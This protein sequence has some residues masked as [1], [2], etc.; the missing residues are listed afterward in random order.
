MNLKRAIRLL[1]TSPLLQ[2]VL[3]AID[4][5]LWLVDTG[6]MWSVRPSKPEKP[7]VLLLKL[8]S[9]G[10]YLLVRNYV[11]LLKSHPDYQPYSFCLAGNVAFRQMAEFADADL[12]DSFIWIDI[13][14]VSTRPLYR[15]AVARQLHKRGFIVSI[16]PTYSRVLVLD[17]FLTRVAGATVRIGCTTDLANCSRLEAN[18]G[19]HYFSRLVPS[20]T[21]VVF[22]A[23]RNRQLFSQLLGE[24][25]PL[26]VL[27]LPPAPKPALTLPDSFVIVSP[28]AGAPDKIWPMDRFADS[29]V[30]L[31]SLRPDWYIVVTGT[32]AE[33]P[34]YTQLRQYLPAPIHLESLMGKLS[35][36]ELVWVVD[37]AALV[38]A[39]DSGIVHIAAAVGTP[40]LSLSAGKAIVRWHP[41]PAEI[42]PQVRHV[43]PAFFDEW[44]GRLDELAPQVV[45][46]AP[47]PIEQLTVDRVKEAIS[48]IVSETH[49]FSNPFT[50]K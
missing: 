40:C 22:E 36:A 27:T 17:D 7:A 39:N 26:S 43:Y 2:P 48:Q 28:G 45:A 50:E 41:Y 10:D 13:Y 16:N 38:L 14:R 30:W 8:D 15:F 29:L 21:G 19:D 5:L 9:L 18:W 44:Q 11:R 1:K 37:K 12:F 35:Q 42:A 33:I 23:E 49:Q 34:L 4:A 46:T 31:H 3:L 20:A 25:L 6:A 32:T 24:S 47:V